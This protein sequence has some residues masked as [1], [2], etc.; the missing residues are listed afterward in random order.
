MNIELMKEEELTALLLMCKTLPVDKQMKL[1]L[2]L[3]NGKSAITRHLEAVSDQYK[4]VMETIENHM[5]AQA[6]AQNVTGFNVANVG[7]SYTAE[8]K[9]IT[10]ADDN[11]FFKFVLDSGDLDFLERRVAV[12]RVDAYMKENPGTVVPGLNI[13]REK[14]MRVRKA[15]EKA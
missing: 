14:V 12:T 2:K 8:T 1:Y 6:Q 5:L 11:A 7:T 3:R 10:I 13:F 4:L 9:K 15:N